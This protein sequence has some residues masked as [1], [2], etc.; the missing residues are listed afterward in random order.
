MHRLQWRHWVILRWKEHAPCVPEFQVLP[1]V[2]P[3]CWPAVPAWCSG[4]L[5]ECMSGVFLLHWLPCRRDRS[6]GSYS[7]AL[8]L[9]VPGEWS[10]D[11]NYLDMVSSTGQQLPELHLG[12]LLYL[13][14]NVRLYKVFKSILV[15]GSGE[16]QRR[17]SFIQCYRLYCSDLLVSWLLGI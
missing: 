9:C 14:R 8:D 2:L 7:E 13:N 5:R 11:R 6:T 4:K 15:S 12:R 10:T 1:A 16:C 17:L 3:L